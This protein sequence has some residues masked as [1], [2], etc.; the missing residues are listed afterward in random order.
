MACM[1]KEGWLKAQA[2]TKETYAKRLAEKKSKYSSDPKRC[3]KCNEPIEYEKQSRNKFCSQSCAASYNNIGVMRNP[4]V[5]KNIGSDLCL[6]CGKRNKS[7]KHYYCSYECREQ[8][9]YVSFI[10]KWKNGEDLNLSSEKLSVP[11]RKYIF[12][13]Y[14]SKCV[15]CGWSEVNSSTGKIPLHVDHIDGD[16]S[17]N[18]ESNLTLLC[19]NCHALT[20]NF[21]ALNKGKS[22]REYRNRWRQKHKQNTNTH[23]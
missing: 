8:H 12:E 4:R 9:R 21:G 22:K 5:E 14:D 1:D 15:K 20:P 18:V 23:P 2:K 19:P 16:S 17:N 3:I 11:I 10:N 7:F 13:K 6:N